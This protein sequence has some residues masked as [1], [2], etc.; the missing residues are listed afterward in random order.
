MEWFAW[1][2]LLYFE[3]ADIPLHLVLTTFQIEFSSLNS[4]IFDRPNGCGLGWLVHVLVYRYSLIINICEW[5]VPID[6]VTM[7]LE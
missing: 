1:C 2:I 4:E 5:N 3:G 6:L 7:I